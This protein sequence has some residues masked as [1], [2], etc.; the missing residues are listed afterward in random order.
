M[1]KAKKLDMAHFQDEYTKLKNAIASFA[2]FSPQLQ[3][4]SERISAIVQPKREVPRD[5]AISLLAT[6]AV[7]A[8]AIDALFTRFKFML[9]NA[10]LRAI[11]D[12]LAEL[13]V[14][15]CGLLSDARKTFAQ[16]NDEIRKPALCLGLIE[17]EESNARQGRSTAL[18]LLLSSYEGVNY[19]DWRKSWRETPVHEKIVDRMSNGTRAHEIRYELLCEL[20]ATAAAVSSSKRVKKDGVVTTPIEGIEYILHSVN[21][22]LQAEFGAKLS[23]IEKVLDPFAGVSNF[24]FILIY[25]GIIPVE[26][27][28]YVYLHVLRQNELDLFAYTIGLIAVEAAYHDVMQASEYTPYPGFKWCDTFKIPCAK[29][30]A[31]IGGQQNRKATK[32]KMKDT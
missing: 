2:V 5:M 20:Y 25:S 9:R 32:K 14:V 23:D 22:V 18:G 26:E 28:P 7:M 4:F 13:D 31:P 3:T 24:A 10:M 11:A 1:N 15:S 6:C 8:P 27:L 29:W 30:R 19:A 16:L 17:T 12:T 21:E